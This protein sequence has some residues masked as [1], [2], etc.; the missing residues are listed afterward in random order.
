MVQEDWDAL[1]AQMASPWGSM[2]L[3]CDQFVLTLQQG[4]CGK[5]RSWSTN[6]Y[7]DGVF[8][9]EWMR[10]DDGEPKHEESR[11]FMRKVGRALHSKKEVEVYRKLWGKREA[12]K[13]AAKKWF[14]FDPSWKSF[15]SLKKH[16]LTNNTS[17]ERLH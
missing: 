16:L 10:S 6:V 12:D 17:I 5:S 2:T 4:A 15:N 8:K 11:R 13:V 3:K 14:H 9:G 7:V 1:K